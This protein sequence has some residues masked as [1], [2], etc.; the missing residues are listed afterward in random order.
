MF[1][2]RL[3][4]STKFFPRRRQA[5]T[6][7]SKNSARPS[8]CKIPNSLPTVPSPRSTCNGLFSSFSWNLRSLP[9][10]LLISKFRLGYPTMPM[11]RLLSMFGNQF[12]EGSL[13]WR[14]LLEI[15]SK[16]FSCQNVGSFSL[17]S[18]KTVTSPEFER[19]WTNSVR[20]GVRRNR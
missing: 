16:L 14:L 6:S 5:Q 12:L 7:S 18:W 10:Y 2:Y 11:R 17:V 3:L 9:P 13:R 1:R 19:G 8:S 20:S 4:S 15:I